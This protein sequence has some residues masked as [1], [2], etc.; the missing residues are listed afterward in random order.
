MSGCNFQPRLD[1]FFDGEMNAVDHATFRKHLENC[2]ECSAALMQ[3]ERMSQVFAGM[4][5]QAA[6]DVQPDE[7]SRL[8][9]AVDREMQRSAFKV[10]RSFWRTAGLISGLAASVLIVASA[11]LSETPVRPIPGLPRP[12]FVEAPVHDWG[13]V[14]VNLRV[15]PLPVRSLDT[16][17]DQSRL[18]DAH[19][20]LT[21]WML[22]GLKGTGGR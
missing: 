22:D 20:K 4:R 19:A 3:M 13:D 6:E 15:D 7:I 17:P 8:H 21:D 16:N 14:A 5:E 2:S 9:A 11:W 18:A 1:A 10:D 12:G